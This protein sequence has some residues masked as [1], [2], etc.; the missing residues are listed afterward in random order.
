MNDSSKELLDEIREAFKQMPNDPEGLAGWLLTNYE[1]RK[2]GSAEP[3]VFFDKKSSSASEDNLKIA[4]NPV[5][6][7]LK[8]TGMSKRIEESRQK[9]LSN[10]AKKITTGEVEQEQLEP[11]EDELEGDVDQP[12]LVLPDN[13]RISKA[14]ANTD[15]NEVRPDPETQAAYSKM[16]DGESLSAEEYQEMERLKRV[17]KQ[18]DV[19]SGNV[20]KARGGFSRD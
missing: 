19:L 13:A 3:T 4:N 6:K 5:H 9:A 7:F 17:R 18:Q 2:V 14:L 8:N 16:F 11:T 20:D 10:L 15:L 12:D 1:I